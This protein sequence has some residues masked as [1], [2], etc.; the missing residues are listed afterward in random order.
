MRVER[1]ITGSLCVIL[2]LCALTACTKTGNNEQN[3]GTEASSG[4]KYHTIYFKD[5]TEREEVT[6]VF[7]NSNNM[8]SKEVRMTEVNTDNDGFIYSCEGD[9]SAYNMMRFRYDGI[10]TEKVCFNQCVSG[11][12]N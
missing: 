10:N 12:Y 5:D 9:A 3:S 1:I 2:C 8:E 7:Y 4:E 11:W 6:A